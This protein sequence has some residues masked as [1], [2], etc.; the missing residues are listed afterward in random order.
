ML[1]SV[2]QT[3]LWPCFDL[4]VMESNGMVINSVSFPVE[5][6]G[7]GNSSRMVAKSDSQSAHADKIAL[8]KFTKGSARS[9]LSFLPVA[10][11][12]RGD[13]NQRK[14]QTIRIERSE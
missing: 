14:N 4:L 2:E 7:W 8:S 9:M 5:P 1:F 12:S 10:F 6:I 3:E 13:E 11:F